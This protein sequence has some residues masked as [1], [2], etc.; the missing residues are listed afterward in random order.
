MAVLKLG[1]QTIS[2]ASLKEVQVPETTWNGCYLKMFAPDTQPQQ[3]YIGGDVPPNNVDVIIPFSG[4]LYEY[5]LSYKFR[6]TGI[7]S[8][9]A[10][11]I[12]TC[13]NYACEKMCQF[14]FRLEEFHMDK[15][16]GFSSGNGALNNCCTG[17]KRLVTATLNS[18]ETASSYGASQSTFSYCSALTTK[19]V[20]PKLKT[21]SGS[22]ALQGFFS[23]CTSMTEQE[24]T[25]LEE[26]TGSSAMSTMFRDCT[27]LTKISFPKLT[28]ISGT[29][30]FNQFCMNC[31][32][33]QTVEFP[34]L[35]NIGPASG[36]STSNYGHFSNAFPSGV[37]G[38]NLSLSFPKLVKIY[39]GT[40]STSNVDVFLNCAGIKKLYFKSL[41]SITG[42]NNTAASRMFTGCN[43][44]TEIHFGLVNQAAIEA[45]AGYT[46]LWGRGAGNATVY[47]D[48]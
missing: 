2:P 33:L 41:S 35:L 7:K 40:T 29:N 22:S 37:G 36:T 13:C 30:A 16:T 21:V 11:N 1:T 47:F 34:E 27:S 19:S 8:F 12:T 15:L 26:I 3:L 17:C 18:V 45:S 9:D 10:P 44:L 25:S 43:N 39:N 48:L 32:A 28:L 42:Y 38:N 31:T 4:Q 5:T 6:G 46:T 14:C 20:M 24:F 23:Y